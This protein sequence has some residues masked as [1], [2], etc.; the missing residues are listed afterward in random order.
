MQGWLVG[1][2]ILGWYF[3]DDI[4][5]CG[6]ECCSYLLVVDVDLNM[7]FG[8]VMVSWDIG[9]GDMV[10]MLDLFILWLIFWLL[11]M[12]LVIVDLVWVDGSEVVVLLCSILCC[13]FDWFKVCGLVV[14]VVNE[15]EF[16]VF[17]Q[18]YCQVWVSGY[19]GLI[20]VSDYNIDYVILVFLWMEL[21]LCDIWLG[22]V[23]VGL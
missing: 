19:C 11:G 15:L 7:V 5:I 23:G 3:V 16:I 20:L 13:Q 14:D 12:V 10:M 9:Y 17:D 1:K 2:W 8:Y 18:L 22:M 21:L 4:V 6:V